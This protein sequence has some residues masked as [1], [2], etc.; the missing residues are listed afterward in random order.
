[1]LRQ[2]LP[3]AHRYS[4]ASLTGVTRYADW[5]SSAS[6]LYAAKGDSHLALGPRPTHELQTFARW[7][8]D[9]KRAELTRDEIAEKYLAMEGGPE[10]LAYNLDSAANA[11]NT[12]IQLDENSARAYRGLGNMYFDQKDYRP[13]GR[14]FVK[15]LKLA[16]DAVDRPFVLE[17]LHQIKAELIK[18]TETNQ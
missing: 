7:E 6:F 3:I 2:I 15:Y 5:I 10:R 12:T 4:A 16:P 1:V 17:N 13:A 9:G 11:Y 18:Q 14:N 8:L